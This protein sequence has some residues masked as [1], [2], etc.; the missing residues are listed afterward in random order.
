MPKCTSIDPL[1]TSYVDDE[2]GA[3]ERRLVDEHL[4]ACPPCRIRV[5]A[6]RA[7]REL[8]RAKR[9]ELGPPGAPD[10]LRARCASL[11]RSS[12]QQ[13]DAGASAAWRTRFTPYALAATLVLVVS[14][15]FLYQMTAR[16]ARLMAAELT[17]DHVKCFG[18]LNPLFRTQ[19]EPEVVEQAM[20]SGFGWHMHLPVSAE[21]AGL[22]LVGARP[23]LYGEGLVAH[24]MYRHNGEPVSVFMLPKTVRA[25]E[26]VDVM[27]HEASIWSAGGRT[28]VLVA[29][30]PRAE[31]TRLTSYIQAA[32]R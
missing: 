9:A 4:R 25:E 32:L 21:R 14:G 26:I 18:L 7:V 20:A 10:A 31:I 11:T 24:I 3:G 5:A 13:V 19:D 28:F 6:E 29:R 30:E 22:E 27:G 16:S 17:A 2:I 12:R 8:V 1:V 15:A 23:C